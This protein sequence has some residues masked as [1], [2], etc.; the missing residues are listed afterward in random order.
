MHSRFL[1]CVYPA[2][3]SA[4]LAHM[5]LMHTAAHEPCPWEVCALDF[6]LLQWIWLDQNNNNITE[7]NQQY[8]EYAYS[9]VSTDTDN[10]LL[11]I[12]STRRI[13]IYSLEL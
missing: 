3:Y 11:R 4:D 9:S 1:C 2:P 10:H 6:C 5:L 8:H 12:V 7:I 13:M